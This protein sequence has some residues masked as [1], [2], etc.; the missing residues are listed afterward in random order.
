MGI[1]SHVRMVHGAMMNTIKY[2]GSHYNTY[3]TNNGLKYHCL[4]LTPDVPS[5]ILDYYPK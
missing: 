1:V 4:N 2:I 5:W 3:I